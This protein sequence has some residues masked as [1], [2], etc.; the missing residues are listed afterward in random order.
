MSEGGISVCTVQDIRHRA[1][2]T[3]THCLVN[4][5]MVIVSCEDA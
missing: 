5:R 3:H 4:V 2:L 1:W